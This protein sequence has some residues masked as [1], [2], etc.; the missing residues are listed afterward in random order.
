M[1]EIERRGRLEKNVHGQARRNRR[2]GD[3]FFQRATMDELHGDEQQ[4]ILLS[5]LIDGDDSRMRQHSGRA[6]FL[7]EAGAKFRNGF[8]IVAKIAANH[9]DRHFPP[10]HLV[11]GQI[12][13]PHAP[14]ADELLN[15][16]LPDHSTGR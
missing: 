12:D 2:I 8:R 4:V 6:S 9:F 13:F 7:Q 11:H 3:Q 16:V 14:A 15:S 10:D 1:G 5:S